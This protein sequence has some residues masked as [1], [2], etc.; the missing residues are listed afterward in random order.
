MI[1]EGRGFTLVELLVVISIIGV[2]ASLV[3]ISFTS[4]QKQARDTQRKSDIRQ[5]QNALEN[6]ANKNNGF[7]PSRNDDS[8]VSCPSS[9]CSDLGISSCPE[10]PRNSRDDSF[11]Y[12]Y[13]SDGS[14]SGA[15]DGIKY[16]LWLRLENKDSYWAIC[17]DGRIGEVSSGIPPSGGTCPL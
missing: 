15:I 10:D 12:R 4:S 16:V 1:N 17:S 13:Q 14:G 2:L 3:M 7:Y 5:Y 6:F 11:V 9:L 8:G